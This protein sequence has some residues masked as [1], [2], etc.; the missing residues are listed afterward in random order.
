MSLSQRLTV[1]NKIYRLYDDFADDLNIACQKY[2]AACC[3]PDVT[4]TTLEGYLIADHFISK[5]RT[6][7]FT[8]IRTAISDRRFKPQTTFNRLA[9]LCAKGDDPPREAHKESNENCLL[10]TKNLC[11]IYPLRP[12]G[13][14]CLT[15]KH[16]CSQ[17]GY[18]QVDPLVITVNTVYLQIIEHIDS[19]GF[20]GNLA[21]ILL[22]MAG[23]E[24]R[25][26]YRMNTLKH[27]GADF[28]PNMPIKVLMVPP[29]HRDQ[30][31]P[32]LK[33]LIGIKVA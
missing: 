30:V 20:S 6:D 14:R 32:I 19:T 25:D 33:T 2:C 11:P 24:N 9:L 13:C 16:D 29:E 3:T 15:S 10:L 31:K 12:F 22:L 17:T 4:M 7:L 21:D 5:G 28:V 26:H 23:K 27:L 1:L 8:H 18:A